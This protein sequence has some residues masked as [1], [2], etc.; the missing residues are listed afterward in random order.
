MI[1][2]SVLNNPHSKFIVRELNAQSTRTK[3]NQINK[4]LRAF[5]SVVYSRYLPV[6]AIIERTCIQYVC[7][8]ISRFSNQYLG[9]D[10]VDKRRKYAEKWR[11]WELSAAYCLAKK[12]LITFWT[13][14]S[15]YSVFYFLRFPRK[16]QLLISSAFGTR[17]KRRVS[18][19]LRPTVCKYCYNI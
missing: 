8:K 14:D 19:K 7:S 10:T 2:L 11:F 16:S 5:R 9:C 15:K 12:C 17:Q 13:A 3:P 4:C 18:G 6:F 1:I